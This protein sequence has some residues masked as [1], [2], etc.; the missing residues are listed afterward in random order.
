LV[1][2][3]IAA[4]Q[5]LVATAR[6]RPRSLSPMWIPNGGGA[7]EDRKL[8]DAEMA[9]HKEFKKAKLKDRARKK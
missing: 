3:N 4:R 9:D 8:A 6:C 7:A 5:A 2:V 1:V